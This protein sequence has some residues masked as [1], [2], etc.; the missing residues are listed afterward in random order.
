MSHNMQ[1][2]FD[3]EY[4]QQNASTDAFTFYEIR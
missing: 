3:F 2:L 1:T 4:A